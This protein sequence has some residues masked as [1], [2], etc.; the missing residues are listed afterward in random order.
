MIYL[1]S[2]HCCSQQLGEEGDPDHLSARDHIPSSTSIA[3]ALLN[4]SAFQQKLHLR[5]YW[6]SVC[7][8]TVLQLP[9]KYESLKSVN[10]QVVCAAT[11]HTTHSY[12]G[13][14]IWDIVSTLT[15]NHKYK[16]SLLQ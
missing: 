3:E 13:P 10:G 14:W 12:E 9:E 1:C 4:Y 16:Q 6:F 5:K 7:G 2:F 15:Q 11:D 8:I